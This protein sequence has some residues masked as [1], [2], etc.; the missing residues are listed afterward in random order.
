M[1]WNKKNF[2]CGTLKSLQSS[3]LCCQSILNYLDILNYC[4]PS[5]LFILMWLL[6]L[7]FVGPHD[8]HISNLLFVLLQ[9]LGLSLAGSGSLRWFLWRA[10]G[11]TGSCRWLIWGFYRFLWAW[12]IPGFWSY[13]VWAG[14]GHWSGVGTLNVMH[15]GVP[16]C[17]ALVGFLPLAVVGAGGQMGPQALGVPVCICGGGVLVFVCLCGLVGTEVS[18]QGWRSDFLRLTDAHRVLANFLLFFYCT[19]LCISLCFL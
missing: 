15:S 19:I 11:P 13:C 3:N 12:V 2:G 5:T 9:E 1:F 6:S 8:Y 18:L 17:L 4:K 16:L 14:S 7:A 10:L